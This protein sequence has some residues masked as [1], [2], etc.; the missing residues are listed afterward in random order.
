MRSI[1]INV[2]S[3]TS[4]TPKE[5][6][7]EVYKSIEADTAL[8]LLYGKAQSFAGAVSEREDLRSPKGC[9]QKYLS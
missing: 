2:T 4:L 9:R 5:E 7:S 3:L 8:R 1:G 6:L